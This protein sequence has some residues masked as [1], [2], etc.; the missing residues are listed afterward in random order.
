[1]FRLILRIICNF[2]QGNFLD[3]ALIC[4]LK[5]DTIRENRVLFIRF[6]STRLTLRDD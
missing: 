6:L 1:M 2:P 3:L 5:Y 4:A